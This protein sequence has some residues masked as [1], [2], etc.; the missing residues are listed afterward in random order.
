MKS[1]MRI[2]MFEI[3]VRSL[4]LVMIAIVL[5]SCGNKQAYRTKTNRY[6][7]GFS[8]EQSDDYTKVV[9]YNPWHEDQILANYYLVRDEQ[10]VTPSDGQRLKVP[11]GRL[12]TTSS[13]HIGFIAEL[14][15]LGSVAGVC[16]PELIYNNEFLDSSVTA[17]ADIGDAMQVNVEKVLL[18]A[19]DAVMVSTYAQGDMASEL[20]IKLSVPVI[21]NNEWT[22]STPLA[23]AEWIRFVAAFFDCLPTADSL[24]AEVEKSYLD[25]VGKVD[26]YVGERQTIMSG[27]NFRGTW[28]V[29]AGNTY[30][31]ALFRDAGAEYYYSNDSSYASIPLTIENVVRNF[32]DADVWVGSNAE[33]LDELKTIDEKHTW[34]KA[35]K[36]GRVYNFR[37]RLR[38]TGANDFW[39]RGV[40]HP[41]LILSDLINILYPGLLDSEEL[42]FAKHLE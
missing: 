20:L 23:R 38:P 25:L 32:A 1:N 30:M 2:P 15:R 33:T 40:V 17:V 22:E 21:F 42:Y 19:P 34:F 27:N 29:P 14:D 16:N 39:E 7:Q 26:G 5:M 11:V 3:K 18:S 12:A 24:F 6:A 41:E 13:T 37:K 35:Y 4:S 9:V 31:G 36:N 8:I 28:Y 10:V